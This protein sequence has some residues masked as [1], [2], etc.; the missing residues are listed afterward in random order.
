[1]SLGLAGI[2]MRI[3][4]ADNNRSKKKSLG[5]DFPPQKN[6]GIFRWTASLKCDTDN[7]GG[8]RQQN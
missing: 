4:A 7:R 8:S 3:L 6:D 2:F 1:M 5:T